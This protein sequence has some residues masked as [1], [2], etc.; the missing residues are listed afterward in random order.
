MQGML[1]HFMLRFKVVG[2]VRPH[3]SHPNSCSGCSDALWEQLCCTFA[4]DLHDRATLLLVVKSF[5][6][7]KK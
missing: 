4:T 7:R 5:I 2:L 6:N 1:C 3:R